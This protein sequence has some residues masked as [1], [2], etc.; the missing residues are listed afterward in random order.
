MRKF[1]HNTE[2]D[3]ADKEVEYLR[4][5]KSST[6]LNLFSG[7]KNFI[8]ILHTKYSSHPRARL[9]EEGK[10]FI[11]PPISHVVLVFKTI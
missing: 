10:T 6:D 11:L 1:K 7:P 4:A 8:Y 3:I 2:F 5:E 9:R